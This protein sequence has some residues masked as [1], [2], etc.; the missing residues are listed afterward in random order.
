[1]I[2]NNNTLFPSGLCVFLALEKGDDVAVIFM[3]DRILNKY[4]KKNSFFAFFF[5]GGGAF[6]W[7]FFVFLVFSL[8]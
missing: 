7:A 4:F 3:F 2:L 5:L 6:F 8:I 1:L